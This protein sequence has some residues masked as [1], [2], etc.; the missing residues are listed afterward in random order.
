MEEIDDAMASKPADSNPNAERAHKPSSKVR[1]EGEL[2]SSSDGNDDNEN[3]ACS[4]LQSAGTATP[5]AG[6]SPVA[7]M[8][9]VTQG[10]QAGSSD[11]H[12]RT[13]TQR[14]F[15][16]SSDKNRVPLKSPKTA[17]RPPLGPSNNNLVIRF[18]DDDSGSDSEEYRQDKALETKGNMTVVEGNQR[19][20]V[21]SSAE[22]TKLRQ[23]ARNV[24]KVL[25]KKNSLSR[26][27]MS[28]TTTIQG[29]NSRGAGNS[30]VEQGSRWRNFNSVKKSLD[31]DR[32]GDKGVG[33]NTTKLQD[34]RQQIALRE[35]ELKHRSAQQNKESASVLD[36]D[37]NA[38]NIKND[39]ARKHDATAANSIQLESKEPDKKR[40]KVG[41]SINTQLNSGDQQEIPAAKSTFVSEGTA[42]ENIS[43]QNLNKA[44]C[45]QREVSLRRAESSIVK[46]KRQDDKCVAVSPESMPSMANDGADIN[47][48]CNQSGRSSRQ[49]NSCAVLNQTTPLANITSNT[50]P[51][52]L[53]SLELSQE[54]GYGG[55]QPPGSLLYKVTAQNNLIR[56]RDHHEVTP[57]DMTLE[58]SFNNICQG[59]LNNASFWNYLGNSNEHSNITMQSLVEM[60]GSLDKDLEE[61]QEHRHRC[62]I[63]ERNALKAYRKAQRALVEANARCIDLYRRREHYSAHLRSYI[64]ENSSLFSSS[65][66]HEHA[67]VGLDY[68]NSISENANLIPTPSHHMQPEFDGFMQPGCG[69]N[70]HF[71][72]NA[73][74]NAVHRQLGGHNLGSE[75]CSELDAS[76]SEP[77]PHR[78]NNAADGVRSPSN[79]ANISADEDEETFPFDVESIQPSNECRIKDKKFENGQNNSNNES[80]K[81]ILIDS[82]QD[83]LLLEATLRSKLFAQLGTRTL[84]KNISSC[85][86]TEHAVEQ[87]AENDVGRERTHTGNGSLSGI[88]KHKKHDHGGT[89]RQERSIIE[90]SLDIRNQHQTE[91]AS[92]SHSTTDSQDCRL[93]VRQ[94]H[95]LLNSVSSSPPSIVRSAFCHLKVMSPIGLVEL[96]T[97]DQQSQ[98]NDIYNEESAHVNSDKIQSNS[99]IA[100]AIK[101]LSGR[102]FGSYTCNPTV[103]P[104]WPLCMYELRGKCNNDECPWQHVKDYSNGSMYQHNDPDCAGSQPG[105][106]LH[107][108]A[109]SGATKGP[110]YFDVMVAPTY[111]VGL[112]MLRADPLSYQSILARVTSQWWEKCFSISLAISNM[113][114]KP[115]PADGPFLHGSDG[116]IEIDGN[117]NRQSSYFQSRN[118]ILNQLEQAL[119]NNDQSVEMALIILNQE[120][121]NIEGVKKAL[122]VLSRALETDPTSVTLWIFYLLIYYSNTKS[123]GKDDMFSHAVKHNEGSYELWLMY[124]NSRTQFDGRL[125]AYDASIKA[126]CRHASA[127]DRDRM[128][129]SACIL[130]LFLQMMDCLRMSGNVEKAI[131]RSYGLFPEMKISNEPFSL[132][133]SDILACL[134]IS[135][136]CVLWVCCVYLVIY[137]KLPDAVV[138]RFECEKELEIEWPFVDLIDDEKQRAVELVEAA[139]SSVDSY[140]YSESHKS[141]SNLRSA[142]LFAVNLIRCLV[143][144]DCLEQVRNLL[145]KYIKLYPSCLELVLI[146]ARTLKRDFGD[147]SF[148]GFEDALRNWPKEAPGIHCIWNQYVEYALQNASLDFAKELIIRWFHSIWE[149]QCHQSRLSEAVDGGNSSLSQGLGSNA[150]PETS[151]SNPNGIDLMFGYLNLSLQKLLLNNHIEAQLAIDWAMKA[152]T[153]EWFK[154]CLREHAMFLLIAKLSLKEDSPII[155]IKNILESYLDDARLFLISV[156]LSRKFI[157][158]VKKPRVQQLV[159]NILNPVSFDFS[160]VNLLLE[161]WYGPSLL[162]K[163]GELKNLVDFVEAILEIL[164]SNY[165]LAMSVCKLLRRNSNFTNVASAGILFWASS[166]LVGAIFHAIP[167]P[168]EYVWVEAADIL[169]NIAGNEAISERFYEKAFSVYPFSV[170]LWKFYYNLSKTRGNAST[171]VEAAKEKGFLFD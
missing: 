164:P 92:N 17:W 45:S 99:A 53:S 101:D 88:E 145:D 11:I 60:E 84:S 58:S 124:I 110:K 122:D 134:K 7:S 165:P 158:D 70:T 115:F 65:M 33:L 156:P 100:N 148:S 116:R 55:R 168:P 54:T 108:R 83:T 2:S 139:A 111:L 130:D 77:L 41:G 85:D 157:D 52:S 63:E 153:P 162:P 4:A 121:N 82:S 34:L 113:H 48:G 106:I 38:I 59:P 13:S 135:D 50:L 89:D 76:T 155:G 61:A 167:I 23:T 146:S 44:D 56:G 86:N 90:P 141:E 9:K 131:Q 152:A 98:D 3:P 51:K 30:S 73:P 37:H 8:I 1:E 66:Q 149:G 129:D 5:P 14:K 133:H 94:G 28:V 132:S 36:R 163:F 154:H 57:N 21:P 74:I 6:H 10:I 138:E 114:R 18:S 20:S 46:L 147:L 109:C 47:T 15:Q 67:G 78:C 169:G 123:V 142:Q 93:S 32:R 96:Q 105:L 71:I 72:G 161:V 136:K 62:E 102:E 80:D 97:R 104:F 26:P 49:V 69:S 103:N 35:S 144:L 43:L 19:L 12:Y 95:H 31:Q 119:A 75:P 127:S 125:V 171:V 27:F 68:S 137:R 170:N 166:T 16:K 118:G 140:L 39:T 29:A 128:R 159:N 151:N 25:P 64:M 150:S 24:K 79:D 81:K 91:N 112:D 22:S 126:L 42:L 143:A 107:Q 40:L 87:A 120:V 117:W 160:L